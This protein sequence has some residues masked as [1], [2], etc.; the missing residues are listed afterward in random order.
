MSTPS[1]VAA[2]RLG[3]TGKNVVLAEKLVATNATVTLGA[4]PGCT[5]RIPAEFGIRCRVVLKDGELVFGD[6]DRVGAYRDRSAVD[7]RAANPDLTSPLA[8]RERLIVHVG[9]VHLLIKPI[10]VR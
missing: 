8:I 2:F 9:K 3:V 7:L 5:L 10:N 4:E 6:E 1:H